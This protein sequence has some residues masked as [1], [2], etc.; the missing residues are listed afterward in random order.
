MVLVPFPISNAFKVV[1]PAPEIDCEPPV[2][3]NKLVFCAIVP[4]LVKFPFKLIKEL[5]EKTVVL[6]VLVAKLSK[7]A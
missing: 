3:L 7:K 1:V 5:P 6:P 2:S 4:L